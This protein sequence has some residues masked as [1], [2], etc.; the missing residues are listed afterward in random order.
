MIDNTPSMEQAQATLASDI[1]SF[2][3]A[4][5]NRGPGKTLPSLRIGVIDHRY[6]HW[7]VFTAQLR[8]EPISWT[9]RRRGETTPPPCPPAR[10]E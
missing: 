4:L 6:R 5:G 3:D 7:P 1:G 9:N 8:S 10:Y 2:V